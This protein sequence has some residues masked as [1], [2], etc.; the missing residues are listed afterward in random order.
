MDLGQIIDA[1]YKKRQDRLDLERSI[2]DLKEEEQNLKFSIMDMLRETGLKK[3]TGD[4]ATA[5]LRSV[6]VPIVED[7]DDVYKY[8]T[9]N[10]RF[11]LLHKR[12]SI[13]AWRELHEGGVNV[14]GII[15]AEDEDLSL[16]KASRG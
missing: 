9:Q 7:W 13:L 8:I 14:P 5:S 16:T 3:A 15:A 11:D 10:D 4:L 12:I 2:K 6:M 1:Y